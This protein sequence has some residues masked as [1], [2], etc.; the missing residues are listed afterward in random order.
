MIAGARP[1]VLCT[2]VGIPALGP[3]GASAHL[4]G[5][6]RALRAPIIAA[7]R[8]DARGEQDEADLSVL[9]PAVLPGWPTF[10]AR[11]RELNE[12]RVART[13][14]G[15]CRAQ[16]P[17]LVWERHA[18]YSV[19]GTLLPADIPRVLEVNAPLA[20]ERRMF[21]SLTFPWLGGATEAMALRSAS[22]VVTVSSWLVDWARSEGANDVRH[23][24]NGVQPHLGDRE[25]TRRRL[26][27][28]GQLVLGFLGSMKPWHGVERL[29]ELLDAIPE[30]VGLCVGD[31]PIKISHPRLRCVGQVPEREVADYVAAMDIGLAPYGPDA[32]PWFCPLK[33]LAYRAQGTPVVASDIGDCRLLT[34]E[35]GTCGPELVDAIRCWAG[36]RAAVNVRSWDDVVREAL[37]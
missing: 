6:A 24:P 9:V 20:R 16:R 33:I 10:G 34:G 35:G 3:S 36:R 7:S 19:T 32:P 28:D 8:S 1:V 18:L 21:E 29:P 11:Y 27:L 13:V 4:R 37:A 25:G 31:G 26:G 30:A 2:A 23:V 12:I 17:T 22:R 14:V 15:L 5:V